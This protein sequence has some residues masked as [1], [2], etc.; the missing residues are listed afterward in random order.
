MLWARRLDDKNQFIVPTPF[1]EDDN[2]DFHKYP[3]FNG[4]T[5]SYGSRAIQHVDIV[6]PAGGTER[7]D[8]ANGRGGTLNFFG[9]NYDAEFSGW[10]ISDKFLYD[11][12][13]LN[14][15]A[16]FSGPNPKPLGYFLYGCNWSG[17]QAS[18]FC[19]SNNNPIDG[20]TLKYPLS[21]NIVTG[22]AP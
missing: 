21:Q 12:G 10:T 8:L 7:A 13:D 1:I 18:G 19:D 16:L 17:G 2:G 9:G 22:E 14:T 5:D 6:N 4:L 15:N 20:N 3:G 11:D